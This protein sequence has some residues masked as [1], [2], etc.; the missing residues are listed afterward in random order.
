[1]SFFM[2]P[3]KRSKKYAVVKLKPSE[4]WRGLGLGP[5]SFKKTGDKNLP[6]NLSATHF[7]GTHLH[8]QAKGV[9]ESLNFKMMFDNTGARWWFQISLFGEDFQFS[10]I[11]LQMG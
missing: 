6:R 4:T 9:E 7:L 10:L 8:E 1:M 5:C 3:Q 2:R 11:F